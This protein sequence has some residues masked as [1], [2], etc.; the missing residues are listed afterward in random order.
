MN[1]VKDSIIFDLSVDEKISPLFFVI[2]SRPP[3]FLSLNNSFSG[4]KDF[5]LIGNSTF[6]SEP[7]LDFFSKRIIVPMFDLLK[8][9]FRLEMSK[10]S[11]PR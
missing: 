6:L 10:R 11:G 3:S 2:H 5:P 1:F 8:R 7:I 4:E 9:K